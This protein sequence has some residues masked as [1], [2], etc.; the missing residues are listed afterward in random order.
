LAHTV[1]S[2]RCGGFDASGY[3]AATASSQSQTCLV[4]QP[5]YIGGSAE[6]IVGYPGPAGTGKQAFLAPPKELAAK[7]SRRSLNRWSTNRHER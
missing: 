7:S 3:R 4:P 6:L 1:V 5:P 2:I